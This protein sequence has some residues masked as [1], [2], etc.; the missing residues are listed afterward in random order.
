VNRDGINTNKPTIL[1]I[2]GSQRKLGNCELVVKEI[3]KKIGIEH[4]LNLVRLPGLDIRPCNGCYRCI[5]EDGTCGIE[6]DAS[7]IVRQ[8]A[9]AD[10][11]IIAAPVYFLGAHA[12]VKC[13]LDRAFS[14]FTAVENLSPKPCIL[15]TTY[16]MKDRIGVAPQALL[17]LASFLG[18]DIKGSVSFEAA[19]PGDVLK[20][21]KHLQTI[22]RLAKGLFRPA[23]H[24]QQARACPFCGSDIV[25]M[26][27]DDFVCTL[28]HG[29]FHLGDAGKTVRDKKG[30]EVGNI[31]FVR[32]HR[33]WL[34]G[35]KRNFLAN[36]KEIVRLTVPYKEIGR[37]VDPDQT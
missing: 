11:V 13:L 14:F 37:W 3:S 2:I 30:W 10:A 15:V 17:T 31:E 22:D 28:C 20:S 26:R 5:D 29:T 24:R 36:R 9:A 34:R 23:R 25:R 33:E 8:I 21:R 7:F 32:S 4:D 1:G 27:R 16:G 18:F 12:S 19:L 35:M 6:D